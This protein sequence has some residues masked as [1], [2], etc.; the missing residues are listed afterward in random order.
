MDEIAEGKA[1]RDRKNPLVVGADEKIVDESVAA[2]GDR[3]EHGEAGQTLRSHP[4]AGQ[5][6]QEGDDPASDRELDVKSLIDFV[7][8]KTIRDE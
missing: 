2:D 4:P 8:G 1:E 3:E 5:K 6:E 7:L